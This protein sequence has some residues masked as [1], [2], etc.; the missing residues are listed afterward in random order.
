MVDRSPREQP[1]RQRVV[2]TMARRHVWRHFQKERFWSG[3]GR[4]DVWAV[5]WWR[6]GRDGR[7]ANDMRGRHRHLAVRF[8]AVIGVNIE[9]YLIDMLEES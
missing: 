5:V 7:R 2:F 9:V 4:E 3:W 1:M 8:R 6:I